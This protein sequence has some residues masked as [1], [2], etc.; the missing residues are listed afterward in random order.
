MIG[1]CRR[2]R[3]L[4]Q[5]SIP[6]LVLVL[7][8]YFFLYRFLFVVLFFHGFFKRHIF[9]LV[10]SVLKLTKREVHFVNTNQ[11]QGK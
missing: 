3:R 5:R 6:I 2:Q 7:N 4:S 8:S 10:S 9:Y 11:M 1:G